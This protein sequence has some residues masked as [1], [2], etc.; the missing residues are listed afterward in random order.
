MPLVR[1]LATDA[2]DTVPLVRHVLVAHDVPET[3][4]AEGFKDVLRAQ[5]TW[6][7]PMRRVWLVATEKRPSE[8]RDQLK[9]HL[10]RHGAS[11]LVIE[12]NF[13]N[14]AT[15]GVSKEVTA[16]IHGRT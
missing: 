4:L 5:P 16:W 13:S 3:Q 1:R 6:A 8:L 9:P 11:L 10:G 14:W 2:T 7:K 15:S 12:V